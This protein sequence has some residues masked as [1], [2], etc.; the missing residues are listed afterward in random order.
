MIEQNHIDSSTY[1]AFISFLK[2]N[3][4][5]DIIIL[6]HEQPDLDAYASCWGLKELLSRLKLNP[7]VLLPSIPMELNYIL[8]TMNFPL[9]DSD[10][11]KIYKNRGRDTRK[12]IILVDFSNPERIEKKEIKSITDQADIMVAIDHHY[13]KQVGNLNYLLY[14]P[15]NSTSEI[16]T[17][18]I[19]ALD[20]SSILENKDLSTALIGGILIDTSFLDRANSKTFYLLSILSNY[21]SYS[22]IA[23]TLKRIPRNID[24]KIAR[25]KGAQRTK[26]YRIDNTLIV[27]TKVGSYE[28][29]VASSLVKL[30]ADIAIVTSKKQ[31]VTR[32]IGRSRI[33]INLGE[34]F[35]TIADKYGYI[36]GGH[37]GAAV[38]TIQQKNDER[39]ETII[40]ELY[41]SIVN[42]LLKKFSVVA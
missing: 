13:A 37:S 18:L 24:E 35:R 1:M 11:N 14:K 2:E 3:E 10:R 26:I 8:H 19:I 33:N 36:G 42:L 22:K 29:S 27:F 12:C 20:Y 9:F 21:G 31:H 5:K 6:P 40:N 4:C 34:I 15:Y 39:V 38:L 41:K 32:I 28:S 17:E 25:L 16:I 30:G 7:L 23:S